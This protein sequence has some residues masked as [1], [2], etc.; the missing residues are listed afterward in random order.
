MRSNDY[1]DDEKSRIRVF[2]P[3]ERKHQSFVELSEELGR[4]TRAIFS[5]WRKL[6]RQGVRDPKRP[7]TKHGIWTKSEDDVVRG[8]GLVKPSYFLVPGGNPFVA[9]AYRLERSFDAV[10]GRWYDL[11]KE[12][13][14]AEAKRITE[15]GHPAPIEHSDS[16]QPDAKIDRTV[17]TRAAET[18]MQDLQVQVESLQLRMAEKD[19]EIQALFDLIDEHIKESKPVRD[20][21]ARVRP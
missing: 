18:P 3:V 16:T 11:I 17:A 7:V 9:A 6:T 15:G 20:P 19:D 5:I 10:E 8:V 4:E 1:T 21:L 14:L 13:R 2:V 12:E